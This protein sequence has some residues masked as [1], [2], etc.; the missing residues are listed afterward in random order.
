M[1]IYKDIYQY[2]RHTPEM[3]ALLKVKSNSDFPFPFVNLTFCYAV[4]CT[5]LLGSD[6]AYHSNLDSSYKPS[7]NIKYWKVNFWHGASGKI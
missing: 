4:I 3:S 6:T 2:S 1:F 5:D 7:L